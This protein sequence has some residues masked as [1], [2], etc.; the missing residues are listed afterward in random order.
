MLLSLTVLSIA[1]YSLNMLF[2]TG[3]NYIRRGARC[4]KFFYRLMKLHEGVKQIKMSYI[5]SLHLA[6]AFLL[7]LWIC[8]FEWLAF[9][10][11]FTVPSVCAAIK[12]RHSLCYASLIKSWYA[13]MQPS[14]Y[15]RQ[16]SSC[17]CIRGFNVQILWKHLVNINKLKQACS[18]HE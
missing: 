3:L 2:Y 12:C 17:N 18:F 16:R 4:W 15:W 5:L 9:F 8:G 14:K 7:H 11:L 10:W 13:H 1:K 6:G